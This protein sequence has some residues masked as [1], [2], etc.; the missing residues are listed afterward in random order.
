MKIWLSIR[1][2]ILMTAARGNDFARLAVPNSIHALARVIN[3]RSE[4]SGECLWHTT[5]IALVYY[6]QSQGWSRE[7][8]LLLLG[9][10]N[11]ARDEDLDEIAK[12]REKLVEY[13]TGKR[14]EEIESRKVGEEK[15]FFKTMAKRMPRPKPHAPTRT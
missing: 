8:L 12:D 6:W 11:K 14:W 15:E 10:S 5:A 2:R 1:N 9:Y 7:H 3:S 4:R 13:L